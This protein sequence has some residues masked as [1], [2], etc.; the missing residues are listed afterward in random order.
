MA[1]HAAMEPLLSPRSLR[2]ACAAGLGLCVAASISS[3]ANGRPPEVFLPVG[4]S[5]LVYVT[6]GYFVAR[7]RPANRI[8]YLLMLIGVV[9][10][11]FVVFRYLAPVSEIV[12]NLAG[13]LAPLLLSYVLFAF[14]SGH[15]AGRAARV[16]LAAVT[17]FAGV[18]AIAVML[19]LEP[20]IHGVS[21][22]PPCVPNPLRL[23]DLA[24][25]PYVQTV[26]DVGT[27]ASA[28]AVSVL[29]AR[30]WY[31]AHGAARRILAP[32]SSAASSRASGSSPRAWPS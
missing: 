28:L 8:G 27:V 31:Q 22:C 7:R 25:Y 19:T 15:L 2:L 4:I 13:S 1:H 23:T 6:S 20:P 5:G 21:R 10:A 26:G 18:Y 24:V 12:N 3:A 16:T 11:A 17:I 14:P 30:R 9:P 29:S 32:S